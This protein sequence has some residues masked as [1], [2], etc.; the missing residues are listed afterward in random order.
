[1]H[2]GGRLPR[3][4]IHPATLASGV[5]GLLIRFSQNPFAY[6]A[7]VLAPFS[8][9]I[10]GQQP[11]LAAAKPGKTLCVA[12]RT[13]LGYR[14]DIDGLRA[15]SILFVFAY[16]LGVFRVFGG[17]IGVDVFFVIS[18]FLISS[19]LF[20]EMEESRFSL[21]AFYG[22]R[23]RRIFPAL[24][25]MI[26]FTAGAAG[27]YLLPSQREGFTRSLLAAVFS[28][29][30]IYFL[31][32]SHYFHPNWSKPLLHTWSLGVE[33]QFYVLFPLFLIA[34]RRCLPG[35]FREAILSVT[36][37]SFLSS[38]YGV[39]AYPAETFYLPATRLWEFL[40][41]TMICLDLFPAIH[42][43]IGR[44][45]LSALGLLL[46]VVSAFVYSGRTHFP[47]LPAL[48]PCL[49]TVLIIVAGETGTSVV[50]RLLSMKPLVFIGLIS[51]SLYLYHWPIIVFQQISM[52]QFR[53][54]SDRTINTTIL[55]FS[56]LIATLSWRLVESPFRKRR[57]VNA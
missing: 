21:L 40:L 31:Q 44:N 48:V 50:G 5:A 3:L 7:S 17:F 56:L 34:V 23:V 26:L 49:G 18:G 13:R 1:M 10:L 30:N 39:Y 29:S 41:G 54:A 15:I 27:I 52:I 14:P 12:P 38:V 47:G 11:N 51:Y 32:Q 42:S 9:P 35:R 20:R 4:H 28:V 2:Q 57:S 6:I 55:L 45:A 36:A 19:I 22:R 46:V 37:F 43:S 8:T 53:H 24:A 33:E 25:G 16:H